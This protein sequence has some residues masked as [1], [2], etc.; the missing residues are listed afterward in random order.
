M[1]GRTTVEPF[2]ALDRTTVE[3]FVALDRTTVERRVRVGE[4]AHSLKSELRSESWSQVG[5]MVTVR[6]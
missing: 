4:T 1:L 5:V 2:M 3:P 6:R